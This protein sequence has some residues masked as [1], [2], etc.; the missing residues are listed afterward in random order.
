MKI[1]SDVANISL[2]WYLL[3]LPEQMLFKHFTI[4][5]VLFEV[6]FSVFNRNFVSIR[7]AFCC[8]EQLLA[9]N[10]IRCFVLHNCAPSGNLWCIV[11]IYCTATEIFFKKFKI[12]FG[13]SNWNLSQFLNVCSFSYCLEKE[14]KLVSI[15]IQCY[16]VLFEA[17]IRFLQNAEDT[18][19]SSRVHIAWI[20]K[21]FAISYDFLP[22]FET[23]SFQS[24]IYENLLWKTLSSYI[25]VLSEKI[26]QLHCLTLK[27]FDL[28]YLFN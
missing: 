4:Y 1:T 15:S 16:L 22:T 24:K 13:S 9:F 3:K 20:S 23:K 6:S 10:I 2:D 11:Y 19:F 27:W 5:Q 14:R 7:N 12:D 21:R 18:F 8:R 28:G 17:P 26:M 25:S